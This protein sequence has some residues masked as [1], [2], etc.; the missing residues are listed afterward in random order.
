MDGPAPK[1]EKKEDGPKA[2]QKGS[3]VTVTEQQKKPAAAAEEV[4][5]PLPAKKSESR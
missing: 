4:P 5:A 1:S 3:K 2:D